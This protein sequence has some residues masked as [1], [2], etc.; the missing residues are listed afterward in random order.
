MRKALLL[1]LVLCSCR[2][3]TPSG[4][5]STQ[6]QE[7]FAG[8]SFV[9]ELDQDYSVCPDDR[10][11][12]SMTAG[13]TRDTHGLPDEDINDMFRTDEAYERCRDIF[14]AAPFS[15]AMKAIADSRGIKSDDPVRAAALV[16]VDT[17][18]WKWEPFE[19]QQQ[20]DF[21]IYAC[22]D[23]GRQSAIHL[24]KTMCDAR[25]IYL[26]NIGELN[27]GSRVHLVG[28]HEFGHVVDHL[29]GPLPFAA[30]AEDRATM[31]GAFLT[32]CQSRTWQHVYAV[33]RADHDE[34]HPQ[35]EPQRRFILGCQI[36][37]WAAVE[38][39]IAALRRLSNIRVAAV[40]PLREGAAC[41][42]RASD[43]RVARPNLDRCPAMKES[44]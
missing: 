3:A 41:A 7:F 12:V 44:K 33:L 26:T 40:E 30:D 4:E 22:T 37:K 43:R 14:A 34:A 16:V 23:P 25:K 20:D 6:C 29:A 17:V 5:V 19:P 24:Y 36:E 32:Q 31:Y 21:T 42:M 8:G 18:V 10:G 9:D 38:K 1:L 11:M 15:S 2:T 13:G 35:D 28:A 27:L 39:R